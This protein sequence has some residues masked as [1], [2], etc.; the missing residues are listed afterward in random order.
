MEFYSQKKMPQLTLFQ[1]TRF[2]NDD[3]GIVGW[4]VERE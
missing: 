1:K 2:V 3:A 4:L